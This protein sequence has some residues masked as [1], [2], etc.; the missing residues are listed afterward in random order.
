MFD[1]AVLF[2]LVVKGYET[3]RWSECCLHSLFEVQAP[4]HHSVALNLHVD[5]V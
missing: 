4:I 5:M 2:L 1:M 3:G